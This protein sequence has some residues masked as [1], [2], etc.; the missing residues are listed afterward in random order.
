[1]SEESDDRP[2][3]ETAHT[4]PPGTLG[5][6]GTPI[7]AVL[8]DLDGTLCRYRRSPGEV[9]D[10]AFER[11]GLDPLFTVAAYVDAFDRFADEADGM[12][13]LRERCFAT[14]AEE[15]G[16]DP[17]VGRSLARTFAD[18]RDQ[19]DVVALPGAH[20][21][22][23]GLAGRYRI[24]VVT[25]GPRDA[26]LAKLDGLGRRDAFDVVVC[27]GDE[28]PPKPDPEPFE[29]AVATLGVSAAEAAFVGDSPTTDVAGANAAGLVS[30]LVGDREDPECAPDVRL[31]A[32]DD[33]D[34]LLPERGS[35]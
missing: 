2:P 25:N 34:G 33:F 20:D 31:A 18:E 11:E 12:A 14:L 4:R 6:K 27:A 5:D 28:T 13:D 30:V 17:A 8:F 1:M 21:L 16:H 9:L 3:S 10:V 22:L 24:G 7:R 19:R 32:L 29:R 23:D 35:G 15:R 26:Q